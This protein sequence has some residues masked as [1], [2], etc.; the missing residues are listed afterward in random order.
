MII[1]TNDRE[2]LIRTVIF[3]RRL[4]PHSDVL[5]VSPYL[6]LDLFRKTGSVGKL[7]DDLSGDGATVTLITSIPTRA[8]LPHFED[9]GARGIGL[10]FYPDVHSKLYIFSVARNRLRRP[11]EYR[12][13]AVVG[14]ANLTESGL[15]LGKVGNDEVAVE[16]SDKN[17]QALRTIA[18]GLKLR[19][20]DLIKLR[21]LYAASKV[22]TLSKGELR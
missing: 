22:A 9:L 14:S 1:L 12:S 6:S 3:S 2:P 7:L 16:I 4:I 8:D 13:I 19:S 21:T 18:L 5:L 20:I 15:K 10:Y 17:V 11:D